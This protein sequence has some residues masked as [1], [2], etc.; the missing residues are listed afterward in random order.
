MRFIDTKT[1]GFLDYIVGIFL[2]GAPWVFG[3]D[4]GAPQGM[5]FIALGIAAVLYSIFTKYELGIAK[6]ISMKVHLLLDVSSGILLA[7]SPWLF[8]FADQG[9][10]PH[11]IL[12]LFEVGAGIMTKTTA[13]GQYSRSN[14]FG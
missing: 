14:N 1:H 6:I 3:L 10:L 13:T 11:L 12:G 4:P 7:A 8:G 9:Y 2:I 5:I